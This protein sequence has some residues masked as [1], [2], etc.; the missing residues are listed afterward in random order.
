[1][2]GTRSFSGGVHPPHSKHATEHLAVE[3]LAAPARVVIPLSQHIGAPAR[4][5]V[6]AGDEV[7][8]GQVLG[9]AGGFVSCPVHSSVAGKVLSVGPFPHASGRAVAAVEIENNGSDSEAPMVAPVSDW[10][11]ADAKRLVDAVQAAGI[12][13]MGGASFPTH[14]KLSPP[15]G[16]TIDTLIINGAECEPYLTADH[17]LLLERTTEVLDGA[18]IIKKILGAQRLLVA[19]ETNKPD[20]IVEVKKALQGEMGREAELVRLRTKYPQGG[21]KQLINAVTGREVPSGGLPM[22]CGCVVQNVGTALAVYE[23][24]ARGKPLYERV[25]TVTGP[26]VAE[27]RNLLVR[28]GTP[29]RALLEHCRADMVRTRKVV[30]GGPMMGNAQQDLDVPVMKS[31]SGILALDSVTPAERAYDC[32]WCG[33]CHRVCPVHLVPSRFA[34]LSAAG[35]HEEAVAWGLMDCMECGSCAFACPAQINLVHHIKLSKYHVQALRAAQ[36]KQ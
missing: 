16:K 24:I 12:V 4:A 9:E 29:V 31:T 20:A 13:G 2:F 18:L 21:E 10:R 30:M 34:R 27:P 23:A 6:N 17:R 26:T 8:V 32:I 35:R 28:I 36:K 15:E 11:A 14:V 3:P 19:I 7:L 33:N 22:D 5:S 25:V 1:M